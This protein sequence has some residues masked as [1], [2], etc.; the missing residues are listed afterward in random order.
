[1]VDRNTI[2]SSVFLL[3]KDFEMLKHLLVES[4][5]V[6]TQDQKYSSTNKQEFQNFS[7]KLSEFSKAHYGN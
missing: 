2:G 6:G 3:D 1:M 7:L 4:G 5:H